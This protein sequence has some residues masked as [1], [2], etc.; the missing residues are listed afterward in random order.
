MIRLEGSGSSSRIS[1]YRPPRRDNE[2][3]FMFLIFDQY[4]NDPTAQDAHKIP[5]EWGLDVSIILWLERV[6]NDQDQD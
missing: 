4:H 6:V 5:G 3:T 2:E 1:H